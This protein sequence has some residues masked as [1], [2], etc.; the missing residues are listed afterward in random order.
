MGV[1][2]LCQNMAA[3]LASRPDTVLDIEMVN[4]WYQNGVNGDFG[5]L[6]F[7]GQVCRRAGIPH[8]LA[9]SSG[10]QG[11]PFEQ[12]L[13]GAMVI[14]GANL[15]TIHMDRGLG[16]EG[17]RAV[18]QPWDWRDCT[19]PVSHNEP[20]GPRSSVAEMTDPLQLAM[21]RATGILCGVT[22]FVLHNGAGVA[23]QIDPT[24]NRPANLWEV[25]G[26]DAIMEAVR[27]VDTFMP[28]DIWTGRHWNNQ[29]EGNPFY[30]TEIWPDTPRGVNRSYLVETPTG[31]YVCANGIKDVAT[32]INAAGRTV[33]V[34]LFDP[35]VGSVVRS[36]AVAPGG[37][38]TIWPESRDASGNGAYIIKGTYR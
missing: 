5:L 17:W 34:E 26:I 8:V 33:E 7:M 36:E 22:S 1:T 25:P 27:A 32:Y 37:V 11:M 3:I 10:E 24:H 23:G 35:V 19:F 20:I 15:Q 12:V 2:A 29:W 4:E 31:F 16:D 9:L 18:R 6:Q 28:P 21:L 14:A 38:I 13:A 30:C